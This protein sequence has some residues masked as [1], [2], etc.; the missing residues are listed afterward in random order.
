MQI[1]K[2]KTAAITIAILFIFSMGASTTLIPTT[3]AHTP[4]MKLQLIA[5]MNSAP[6]PCGLGQTITL[7]FWLNTPPATANGPYGDRYGGM[8]VTV[9]PPTGANI[10][11]GPFTSDD[12][13]GTTTR[14]TPTELGTYGFT[15]HF[16]GEVLTGST[17]NPVNNPALNTGLTNPYVNDTILPATSAVETVVVQQAAVPLV[18][19][20]P[21]PTTYWETP[22]NS[23]NVVNW[24]NITGAWLG[25]G[26]NANP[27]GA[28]Q[29]NFSSNYNP[30]TTAP[31]TAHLMWTKVEAF[32][33]VLGGPFSGSTSYG[34]YYSIAQY[35]RKF[36]PTI[37]NGYLIY[38]TFPGSSGLPAANVGVDLYTG[39]TI[40][41]DDTTNYGGSDASH[42]ALANG[43]VTQVLCGQILNYISRNQY[44]GEAYFWTTGQPDWI[45]AQV[46]ANPNAPGLHLGFFTSTYN[47]FDAMTGDYILSIV[48][49][50]FSFSNTVDSF[51]DMIGYYTGGGF[52]APLTLVEWNS[53]QCIQ[54]FIGPQASFDGSEWRPPQYGIVN[55]NDGIMWQV[56]IATTYQ[57]NGFGEAGPLT[58]WAINS[59][60][61]VLETG[62]YGLTALIGEAAPGLALSFTTGWAV[63]AGYSATTGQQLWIENITFTPWTSV[64]L[65]CEFLAGDGI[66]ITVERETG[67]IAGWSM[68]TGKSVWSDDVSKQSDTYDAIGSYQGV[69]AGNNL[70]LIGFGGDVW[71][72]NMLSGKINWYTNTTTLQGPAGENTPYGFWPIWEQTGI[73]VADGVLFLA[74]GHEYSP[75]TFLGA[76]ELAVNCT[77]GQLVWKIDGFDI[78]GLPYM[79]YG[80]MTILDGY[81][82]LIEDFGQGP[83]ATTISAPQVGVTT[84]TPITITGSVMDVSAGA[85]QEAVAADFPNGLPCVSDASMTPFMEAV[86]MQQPMPTN[87]TGVPVTL[88]VIDQNGNNRVIG[89]TTTN[90]MGTYGLTWTPDI[91]GK[92]TVIA[93][94]AGTGGYYGSSAETY[95]DASSPAPTTAPTAAPASN[96]ATSSELTY[97]IIAAVIAII[98]AIA[99]VGL[100]L[101]RKKP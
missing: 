44:G 1:T 33:G 30:Y 54:N 71:S 50:T 73:G 72:V 93:T 22:V 28:E 59:G 43:V 42:S 52:G 56:P 62:I 64:S 16:P 86:Y 20:A 40:W 75:P 6:N 3:S 70:Y 57:G 9:I 89:T 80:Q 5:F 27:I 7:D 4:S 25:L 76:Q 18:Q 92:Y 101:I 97:G 68:T 87:I 31:L 63:F 94:F 13:G 41:S 60:V 77:T 74:E 47:M 95:F 51:G 35:E 69:I 24:Y 100:L 79:A 10:T 66:F 14:F 45:T 65:N 36:N 98:I 38:T 85:K 29:Y 21:L 23:Q 11:L 37:I 91:P 8:I 78:N 32:G 96:L 34:D 15:M 2:N 26:R 55:W 12:T 82:N 58:M 83:S 99:I 39:Q 67:V 49:G 19:N 84:A 90:A 61:V 17:D 81:N 88:S 53:T 48:N 46:V